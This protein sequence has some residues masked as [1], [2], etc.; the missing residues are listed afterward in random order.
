ML[1]AETLIADAAAAT[2]LLDFGPDPWR[3]GLDQLLAALREEARLN[4]LGEAIFRDRIGNTLRQRLQLI[5]CVH[6]WP[7][8]E[9]TTIT[10]PLVVLGLPRTGTTALSNLIGADPETRAPRVWESAQPCPPPERATED[11]DPRIAA[12]QAGIDALHA[13]K[14][15]MRVIHDDEA[16]G[17]AESMDL[18]AF[19]FRAYQYAG[20][21]SVPSYVH[22]LLACDLT[23]A[24]EMQRRV[25]QLLCW[26]CPPSRWH[27]RNPGDMFSLESVVSAYPDARFVWCHRDP[28]EVMASVCELVAEVQDLASDHVVRRDIGPRQLT[29][30]ATA[31]DRAIVARARLGEG[32]FIDVFHHELIADPIATLRSVYDAAGWTV[33]ARGLEGARSWIADHERFAHGTHH[34][35]LDD[36]GLTGGQVRERLAR[37]CDRFGV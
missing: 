4:D 26:R 7:E 1:A 5:E 23:P 13:L 12:T 34:P 19:T 31:L 37:Y 6:R 30:W 32:L 8:I 17:I 18:L 27:L 28:S 21:A 14:P 10:G 2:G 36:Y 15:I 11:T 22:W 35:R 24:Y 33:T 20:M 25:L 29:D 16:T 3:D 9:A